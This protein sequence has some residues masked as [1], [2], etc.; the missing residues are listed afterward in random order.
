MN[1]FALH[2]DAR[3]SPISSPE[4]LCIAPILAW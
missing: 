2:T 3:A 4:L 1:R